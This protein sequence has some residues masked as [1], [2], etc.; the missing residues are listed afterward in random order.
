VEG[1]DPVEGLLDRVAPTEGRTRVVAISGP[2]AV[3]KSTL[4]ET[5]ADGLAGRGATVEVVATDGFLLP[6]AVLAERGMLERKGF[7]ETYDLDRLDTLVADARAG[8]SPLLVPVYSHQRYDVLD[9][10]VALQPPDVLVVEGVVALQRRGAD[11]GIYVDAAVEDVTRWYV[12]RFQA[13]V[14]ASADDPTSFY[15]QWVDLDPEAVADLARVV[16]DAVN[17]PNLVDH[18][19]PTQANADVIVRKGPDHAIREVVEA[20]P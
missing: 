11:L 10:P 5:L 7:P 13:L 2:V 18:I 12:E 1:A 19:G 9:E 8:T 17:L 3:G 4:A 20:R 16:W 6:N 15:R 14:V